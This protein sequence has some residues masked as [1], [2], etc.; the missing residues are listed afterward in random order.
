MTLHAGAEDGTEITDG[1]T[2]SEGSIELTVGAGA[3]HIFFAATPVP[4]AV[5][6]VDVIANLAEG[7]LT[8]IGD[9]V[10]LERLRITG[11]ALH[12]I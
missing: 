1:V 4:E 3:G 11:P 6:V 2:I 5:T 9:S 8:F 7:K 12:S 10:F